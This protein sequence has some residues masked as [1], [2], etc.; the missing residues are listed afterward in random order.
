MQ[1]FLS[2]AP[3]A[4]TGTFPPRSLGAARPDAT[5]ALCQT[6][7]LAGVRGSDGNT[8]Q[9]LPC[10]GEEVKL[11]QKKFMARLASQEL[12]ETSQLATWGIS[13]RVSQPP[14]LNRDLRVCSISAWSFDS[15]LVTSC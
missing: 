11:C 7:H 3:A 9:P 8:P 5:A 1:L 13:K 2:D 14:L 4:S 10:R 12:Q 15:T 6:K